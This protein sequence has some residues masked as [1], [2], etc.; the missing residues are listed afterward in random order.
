MKIL[1][2]QDT[3]WIRRNPIQH[4]HLVERMV[5]RGH[6]VRVVDYEILW[7]AEG[8]K[9]LFTRREIFQVSRILKDANHTVIRPGILKIPV[10]DYVSML[11]TYRKEI[12]LQI[13]E[14]NPDIIIGDTILTPYLAYKVAKKNNI[15]TIFYVLDINHKLIPFKFLQ[16][17]G[18]M[19]ESKNIRDADLV[20][21]INEGLREYVI[22]MGANPAK[23]LVLRAGINPQM[24]DPRIDGGEIREMYGI[25]KDDIVL[26]FVGWLHHSN[27]LKEVALELAQMQN[28]NIKLLV[29]GDGDAY[30]ELQR[31]RK[32]HNLQ[33]RLILTGRKPYDEIPSF[34]AAADIC[35]LPSYPNEPIMQHI[36]P[37]KMYDYTAMGRPVIATKLPGL[38][39]EFGEDNG[40]VYID[41]P[42]DA[43][44]KAMEL[45]QG[46]KVKELGSKARSFVEGYSWDTITDEFERIIQ[47]VIIAK[48]QAKSA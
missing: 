48:K 20:I 38:V 13:R 5:L 6:E 24:F 3:D 17:I 28:H 26:F 47:E 41:R 14:F 34:I 44:A 42:E 37:I 10:L 25:E 29:V 19:I 9:E 22:R 1:L 40:V 2:V 16:P 11:F 7:R 39:K 43:V 45:I 27:G 35:L 18:K 33:N 15:P 31:M 8:R 23:A 4:N 36:V 30:K 21:A 12:N 46:G 32:D